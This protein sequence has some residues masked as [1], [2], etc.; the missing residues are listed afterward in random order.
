MLVARQD[1]DFASH[2]YVE[3]LP[4]N[5]KGISSKYVNSTFFFTRDS[6]CFLSSMLPVILMKKKENLSEI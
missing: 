1:D 4:L 6:I 2:P 5:E 3:Y